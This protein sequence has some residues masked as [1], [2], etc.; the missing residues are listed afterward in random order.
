MKLSEENRLDVL[1]EACRLD[2]E[3]HLIMAAGYKTDLIRLEKE[4]FIL[5]PFMLRELF[6]MVERNCRAASR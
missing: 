4:G 2:D 1:Q 5:K 6:H 3:I